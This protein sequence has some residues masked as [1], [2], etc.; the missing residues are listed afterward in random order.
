MNSRSSFSTSSSFNYNR[1]QLTLKI[2]VVGDSNTGKTSFCNRWVNSSFS[3]E[4]QATIM[5]NFS[6]KVY[7][8]NNRVCNVQ[9]WDIAGQDRS[10]SSPKIF[11]SG[12]HGIIILCDVSDKETVE[13]AAKWKEDIDSHS[14][15]LDGRELPSFLVLNKIDLIDGD[16][17]GDVDGEMNMFVKN[18]NFDK[19]MKVSCKTG[20]NINE[21]MDSILEIIINRLENYCAINHTSFTDERK[22]LILNKRGISKDYK[23]NS[24]DCCY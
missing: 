16:G 17:G 10:V 5:S 19:Y 24:S 21:A 6:F 14:K 2:C 4:Y 3:D 11:T 18:H 12:S 13:N 15:F 20:E 9:F 23:Y 22:S 1:S 8:H 7:K